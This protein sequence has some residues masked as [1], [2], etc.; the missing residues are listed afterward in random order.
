MGDD[1]RHDSKMM[2][3][4]IQLMDQTIGK[5][6]KADVDAEV[7]AWIGSCGG[8]LGSFLENDT[9][10]LDGTSGV[11][12]FGGLYTNTL[13][14]VDAADVKGVPF[15]GGCA[16]YNLSFAKPINDPANPAAVIRT[17][18]SATPSQYSTEL[19]FVLTSFS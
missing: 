1:K 6:D 2:V 7:I 12:L 5:F 11:E 8:R 4:N 14:V 18:D 3:N 16:W 15:S 13:D 17:T 9:R 19:Q 10:C